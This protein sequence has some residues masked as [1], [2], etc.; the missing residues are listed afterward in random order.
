[1]QFTTRLSHFPRPLPNIIIK[2]TKKATLA[3]AIPWTIVI[4][5][6][7]KKER[8][9]K[10]TPPTLSINPGN[11]NQEAKSNRLFN[12]DFRSSYP[13]PSVAPIFIGVIQAKEIIV[14]VCHFIQHIIVLQV[15]RFRKGRPLADHGKLDLFKQLALDSGAG[16]QTASGI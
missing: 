4:N 10:L 1:M 2:T 15:H 12:P 5:E 13:A 11:R 7:K 6:K 14:G 3:R 16:L 9:K 8:K